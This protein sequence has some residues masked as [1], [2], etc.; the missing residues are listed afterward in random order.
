[1]KK[2]LSVLCFFVLSLSKVATADEDVEVGTTEQPMV[3]SRKVAIKNLERKWP[4]TFWLRKAGENWV[5]YSLNPS[6]AGQFPCGEKCDFHI[7]VKGSP[8]VEVRLVQT[9]RYGI[10]WDQNIKNWVI[11]EAN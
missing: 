1:M 11:N 9:K 10:F 6:Q 8:P 3:V 5:K 7:G 4:T 2:Y